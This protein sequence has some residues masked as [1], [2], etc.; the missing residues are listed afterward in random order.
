MYVCMLRMNRIFL[1]LIINILSSSRSPA[2]FLLIKNAVRVVSVL[3]R[4]QTTV[5]W[6]EEE[7]RMDAPVPI[8]IVN[9][10]DIVW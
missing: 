7:M 2:T 8:K 6:V 3:S 10:R 9:I 5:G 1:L 4:V